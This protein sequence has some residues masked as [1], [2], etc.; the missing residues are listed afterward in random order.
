M[1]YNDNE[2]EL[3]DAEMSNMMRSRLKWTACIL[4]MWLLCMGLYLALSVN[5]SLKHEASELNEA[6]FLL[7][8]MISQRVAQQDAHMTTLASLILA[9][10]DRKPE[11]LKQVSDSIM[12]FYPR[13]KAI[14]EV[15]IT[16]RDA[17]ASTSVKPVFSAPFDAA[18]PDFHSLGRDIF[19]QHAGEV[20]SYV[21]P[22]AQHEYL[23]AKKLKDSNPAL[24]LMMQIN[25]ELLIDIDELPKWAN[26]TL[27]LDG[28]VVMEQK[29]PQQ[30]TGWLASPKFSRA[31]DSQSQ[32]LLL[33]MDYPISLADLIDGAS[34][35]VVSVTSLIVLLLFGYS[36]QHQ[37][38]VRRL[39]ASADM[40]EQRSLALERETRLAH[41]ARVNSMG[42]LAS[43]IAH[44]LAQPLTALMSQSRAAERIIEQSGIE[45]AVLK[46]AMAANVREARRAGDMLKRMRDYISNRPPKRVS[47]AINRIIHDTVEL[48]H[49]DLEQRGIA[50]KLDLAP[51]LPQLMADPVELEQV[52]NNLI[53]NSAD[54]LRDSSTADGMITVTTTRESNQVLI[55]VSD[56]GP[57]IAEDLLPR[58][59]EP[60]FTTKKDGMGLGLTLCATLIERIG[61]HIEAQNNET[62]GACFVV[63]LPLHTK[64][65]DA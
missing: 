62:G 30:A 61:G 48:L 12:R 27:V 28:S 10:G 11:L 52:F 64:E 19:V 35:A 26:F 32:P 53:R 55:S 33:T 23:L 36:L 49:S 5:R 16:W 40:A 18:I 1:A 51:D 24:T 29:A 20:R 59:F 9:D 31:I 21:S 41:A 3:R 14:Q 43:G 4:V 57:G 47:V 15:E 65:T 17:S 56:N 54:S 39:Q 45:N 46:K 6:G 22:L 50:L 37:R 8:R 7:H 42:E 63:K 13:I 44:E 58:L 2:A 34:L 60:F 25:P 38:E